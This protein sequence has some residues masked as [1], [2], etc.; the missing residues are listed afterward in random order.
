MDFW[1]KGQTYGGHPYVKWDQMRGS[2]VILHYR[3]TLKVGAGTTNELA[4][5]AGVMPAGS[6][7]A[8]VS[9]AVAQGAAPGTGA[10][11]GAPPG[12]GAFK[13]AKLTGLSLFVPPS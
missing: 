12:P 5:T 13:R 6:A 10:E 3:D 4:T 2:A 9:G 11:D 8:P 1:K 7:R